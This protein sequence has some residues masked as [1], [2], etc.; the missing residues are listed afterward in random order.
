MRESLRK[1]ITTHEIHADLKGWTQLK[2]RDHA[3]RKSVVFGA[4]LVIAMIL[5][6]IIAPPARSMPASYSCVSSH[7]YGQTEFVYPGTQGGSTEISIANLGCNISC[8]NQGFIDNETWF[9][10]DYN[11]NCNSGGHICWVEVGY[12][13]DSHGFNYFWAD[14]RP[15]QSYAIHYFGTA[16]NDLGYYTSFLIERASSTSFE[17]AVNSHTAFY[18]GYSTSNSM[19]PDDSV[20]GQELYGTSGASAPTATFIDNEYKAGGTW[21]YQV[22]SYEV[23]LPPD[24]PVTWRVVSPANGNSN[25]GGTFQS[26]CGC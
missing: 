17:V 7:C 15:N 4:A 13:L 14:L 1:W 20:I 5:S 8:L 22:S 3:T 25:A 10:Q 19:T 23:D 9:Q 11:S 18:T 26:A 12:M 6:F 2:I 24:P 21:H 16:H